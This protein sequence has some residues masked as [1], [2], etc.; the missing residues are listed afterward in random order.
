VPYLVSAQAGS[1]MLF[2]NLILLIVITYILG[3][4]RQPDRSA[5]RA[6]PTTR[7]PDDVQS[8]TIVG[9]KRSATLGAKRDY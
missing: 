9:R 3:R 1:K 5:L 4:R 8:A 6:K 7:H 2:G